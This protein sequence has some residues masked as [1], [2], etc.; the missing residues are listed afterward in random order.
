MPDDAPRRLEC[1]EWLLRCREDLETAAD[2]LGL[3]NTRVRPILFHCQQSVEKALKAFL[4]WH[5]A[6]FAKSHDLRQLGRESSRIDGSLESLLIRAAFLTD[7]AVKFRY[8]GAECEPTLEE[9]NTSLS[10]ARE[11]VEAV[12]AR[13]PIRASSDPR[14]GGSST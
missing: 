9:A 7:Y 2:L 6:P 8:P 1:G 10:I 4:C 11:V 12:E 13:L 3:R 5:D 14:T